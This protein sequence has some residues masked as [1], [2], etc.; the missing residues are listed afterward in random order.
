MMTADTDTIGARYGVEQRGEDVQI[1]FFHKF[2]S[3]TYF[4]PLTTNL[5]LLMTLTDVVVETK[6]EEEFYIGESVDDSPPQPDVDESGMFSFD[7][8]FLSVIYYVLYSK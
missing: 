7:F 8:N 2:L 5:L 6:L 3:K 4:K 1:P